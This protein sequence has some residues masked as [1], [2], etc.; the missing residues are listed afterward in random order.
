[1]QSITLQPKDTKL[2]RPKRHHRST[3]TRNPT[4]PHPTLRHSATRHTA[5][6]TAARRHN[7]TA[8][9]DLNSVA[10]GEA[11]VQ[12][13][14]VKDELP[15]LA[16]PV[17]HVEEDV[18]TALDAL[19]DADGLDGYGGTAGEVDDGHAGAVVCF[20][21]VL[22]QPLSEEFVPAPVARRELL[23]GEFLHDVVGHLVEDAEESFWKFVSCVQQHE[24][25]KALPSLSAA[26][27][28][29][30]GGTLFTVY[31]PGS[32]KSGIV[33]RSWKSNV[34]P[35]ELAAGKGVNVG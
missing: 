30:N 17:H 20:A 10:H 34:L 19:A 1:M 33:W 22:L 11:L 23:G 25:G 6:R 28:P 24:I 27:R 12:L 16:A 18:H 9:R 13:V 31:A 14:V 21:R 5:Q 8:V 32:W 26:T 35:V 2:N 29:A 15:A 4:A 7:R 3:S